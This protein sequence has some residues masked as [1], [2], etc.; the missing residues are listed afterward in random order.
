MAPTNSHYGSITC[1]VTTSVAL[2]DATDN[3]SSTLHFDV[4]YPGG[5]NSHYNGHD[6]IL[7]PM[8]YNEVE[9]TVYDECYNSS[10]CIVIVNVEDKTPPVAVCDQYTA[11][12]LTTG[13]E[14]VVNASSF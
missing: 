1:G 9:F 4:T 14:A 6:P 12:S 7:L 8:G 11:V 3:C 10:S 13:G 5:H 2:P